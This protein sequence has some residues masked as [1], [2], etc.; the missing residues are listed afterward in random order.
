MLN[1]ELKLEFIENGRLTN[2]EMGEI[3]GGAVSCPSVHS[4]DTFNDCGEKGK[5]DC[6]IYINCGSTPTSSRVSCGTKN[7][8]T[9]DFD[10]AVADVSSSVVAITPSVVSIS[11]STP[12]GLM[13]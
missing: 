13:F 7:W 12:I 6:S 1:K 8:V 11:N 4:C 2:G 5:R 3:V 10:I 9:L